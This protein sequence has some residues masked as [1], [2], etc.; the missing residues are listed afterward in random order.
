MCHCLDVPQFIYPFTY[1]RTSQL[2]PSFDNYEWQRYKHP[3]ASFLCEHSFQLLWL[4]SKDC[5][6]LDYM[7]RV[8]SIS[9]SVVFNS[10]GPHGLGPQGFPVHGILQARI[11]KRVAI[12]LLQGIFPTQGSNPV[13]WIIGWC[14]LFYREQ[15]VSFYSVDQPILGTHLL[16]S[17]CI[18][19]WFSFHFSAASSGCLTFSLNIPYMQCGLHIVSTQ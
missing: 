13:S 18:P 10:L 11:L 17:I 8:K 14:F 12:P 4:D 9:C 15:I 2:L 3:R 7:V 6:L 16:Q 19:S 5:D 1:S